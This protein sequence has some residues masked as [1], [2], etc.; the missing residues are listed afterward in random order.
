[1]LGVTI[2]TALLDKKQL[3]RGSGGGSVGK[4]VA[5]Y[6]RDLRFKTCHR[7]NDIYQLYIQNTEKMKI[8]KKR[9]GMGY[10]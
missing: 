3:Q 7:Q 2:D 5:S 10:L 8:K 6:T 1:M 4:A 9:A